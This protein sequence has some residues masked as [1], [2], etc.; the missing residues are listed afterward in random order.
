MGVKFDMFS[1]IDVN[2]ANTHP[3]FAYLKV[4][5][6]G[7]ITNGVKW[8]FTKWVVSKSGVV[9]NRYGPMSGPLKI[10]PEIE[11]LLAE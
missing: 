11:K 4:K 7:F 6:P 5:G 8:N 2:G 3:L 1:K 9:T 10:V